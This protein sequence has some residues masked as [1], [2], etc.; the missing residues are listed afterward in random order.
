MLKSITMAAA[1]DMT[2]LFAFWTPR[3]ILVMFW[4][5][6]IV[7]T[8]IAISTSTLVWVTYRLRYPRRR[9]FK[10]LFNKGVYEFLK[11]FVQIVLPA[12][13]LLY[14]TLAQLWNLPHVEAVMGTISA[15]ATFLGVCLGLSTKEYA[16]TELKYDGV[17]VIESD[18]DRGTST[19]NL[20]NVSQKALETKDE[21]LLR[22]NRTG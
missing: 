19:L 22:V 11:K 20:S 1:L 14:F 16:R 3:D 15:V 18:E 17:V 5:E 10:V 4:I 12:L 8:A 7:F 6:A 13:G 21:I 2:V 9:S